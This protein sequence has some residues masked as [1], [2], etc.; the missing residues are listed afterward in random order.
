MEETPVIESW[1]R[2]PHWRHHPFARLPLELTSIEKA[3]P[4][5]SYSVS[6]SSF[7]MPYGPHDHDARVAPAASTSHLPS[8]TDTTTQTFSRAVPPPSN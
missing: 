7:E 4:P 8:A 2:S 1:A 3:P 5:P 6:G